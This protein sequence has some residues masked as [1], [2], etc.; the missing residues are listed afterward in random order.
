MQN[1][2]DWWATDLLIRVPHETM[3]MLLR[4]Q[5]TA[6]TMRRS[7]TPDFGCYWAV[8][9]ATGTPGACAASVPQ[10]PLVPSM[11]GAQRDTALSAL[12]GVRSGSVQPGRAWRPPPRRRA[13][14]PARCQCRR[15]WLGLGRSQPERAGPGAARCSQPPGPGLRRPGPAPAAGA[16]GARPK[17]RQRAAS[18]RHWGCAQSPPAAGC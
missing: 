6:S 13:A 18:G 10:A 3:M 15:G 2:Q 9:S 5:C 1:R 11:P 17:L 16:W 14:S 4:G 7:L 12:R 8:C